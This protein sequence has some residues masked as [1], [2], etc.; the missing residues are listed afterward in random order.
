MDPLTPN[1]KLYDVPFETH[2]FCGMPYQRLGQSGLK[3]SRIGLG[4]WKFGYPETGD[5]SRVDPQRAMRIFD[6]A[7]EYG[8]TFWDTANRYNMASGNS[9][10]LIGQWFR[11]NPNERRN[12]IL[13]TKL[14]GGMDGVSPNHSRAT[15]S[16]ILES[17]YASMLRMQIEYIDLLYLHRFDVSTP[18]E[19]SLAAIE[20]LIRRDLVRHFAVSNFSPDQLK[21]YQAVEREFNIRVR[22]LA[23]QNRF[24]ILNGED[25]EQ[26]GVLDYCAR[27]GISF[28]PYSPLARGLLTDRYLEPERAGEGDRLFDE[29][30]L[31]RDLTPEILAKMKALAALAKK[32]EMELVQLALAYTLTLPGMGPL[33]PSSSSTAQLKSNA[34][35]GKIVLSDEQLVEIRKALKR[36]P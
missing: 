11:N 17:V 15:R 1:P 36:K 8:V 4:T 12:V 7:I 3:V 28:V 32:W 19:E 30:T 14:Y 29:G 27:S 13:A 22:V 20:D 24:D 34:Q 6:R 33:I 10:R 16:N 5:K 31:Q 2:D 21:L 9:E 26:A 25:P 35:A 18:V 23:V